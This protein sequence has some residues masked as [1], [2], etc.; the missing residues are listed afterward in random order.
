MIRPGRSPKTRMGK[1]LGVLDRLSAEHERT[2]V[3]HE[4][5]VIMEACAAVLPD[6]TRDEVMAAFER[7]IAL[8]VAEQAERN[9]E[10]E[11][12][13][14]HAAEALAIFGGCADVTFEE[15]CRLKAAQ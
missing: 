13:K 3:T 14:R 9:A 4:P 8:G 12:E 2:G 7:R 10:Y 5:P 15:A 6:V 11:V 1:L